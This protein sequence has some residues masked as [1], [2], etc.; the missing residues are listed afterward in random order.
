[1]QLVEALNKVVANG[2]RE[3]AGFVVPTNWSGIL[4]KLAW[5]FSKIS[6]RLG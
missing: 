3:R 6:M 4:T 5:I 1:M 2:D